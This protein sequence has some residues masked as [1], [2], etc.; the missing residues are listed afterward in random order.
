MPRP[1][2][3]KTRK[4]NPLKSG[5]RF[6]LTQR[7]RFKLDVQRLDSE[8]YSQRQIAERLN[9][10]HATVG[11]VLKEIQADYEQAYVDNRKMWVVRELGVLMDLRRRAFEEIAALKANGK[12]KRVT[13]TGSSE[14]GGYSE[15]AETVEDPEL[16]GWHKLVLETVQETAELMGLKKLPDQ[17][18]VQVN[19]NQVNVFDQ[20]LGA[21]LASPGPARA[22]DPGEAAPPAVADVTPQEPAP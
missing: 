19:A 17:V 11:T 18:F 15:E 13:K 4:P 6:T 22:A 1:V 20:L 9:C 8:G 16:L 14:K 10:A 5:P 7:E 3:A 21:L 12:K 2:G